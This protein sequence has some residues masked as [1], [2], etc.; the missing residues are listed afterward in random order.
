VILRLA[1]QWAG[2]IALLDHH[3]AAADDDPVEVVEP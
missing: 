1:H 2:V 3:D